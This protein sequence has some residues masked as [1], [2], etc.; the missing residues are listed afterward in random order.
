HRC[1]TAVGELP[2]T[3]TPV[4][5]GQQIRVGQGKRLFGLW[6]GKYVKQFLANSHGVFPS[7]PASETGG[8][9]ID[10][11]GARPPPALRPHPIVDA[12]DAI[13]PDTRRYLVFVALVHQTFGSQDNP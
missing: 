4:D 13:F 9:P 7:L 3:Y 8:R 11:V 12:P 2:L 1:P 6:T 10:P 5:A